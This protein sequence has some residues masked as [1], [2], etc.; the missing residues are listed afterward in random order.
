M[1]ARLTN[2]GG[3]SGVISEARGN[4]SG[5]MALITNPLVLVGGAVA[6]YIA[7]GD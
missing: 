5:I 4:D 3:A 6:A 1:I 2:G 7:M